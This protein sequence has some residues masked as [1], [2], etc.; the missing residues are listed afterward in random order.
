MDVWYRVSDRFPEYKLHI[1]PFEDDRT[2]ILTEIESLGKKFDFLVA[3][4][5]SK[6]W[7]SRCNFLKLGEYKQ[8]VAVPAP[9]LWQKENPFRSRIYSDK[10]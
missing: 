5:D 6:K 3:V 9:T 2:G 10:P 1:V 7:L 4:C 8:C